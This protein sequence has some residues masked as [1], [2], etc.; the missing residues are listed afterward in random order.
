[1]QTKFDIGDKVLVPFEV[2]EII[3]TGDDIIYKMKNTSKKGGVD[4]TYRS[5]EEIYGLE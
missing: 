1:M 5:E 4:T 3:V 2:V